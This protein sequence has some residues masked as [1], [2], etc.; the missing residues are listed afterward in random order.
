ML[1]SSVWANQPLSLGQAGQ[2]ILWPLIFLCWVEWVHGWLAQVKVSNT[3][4]KLEEESPTGGTR[5]TWC[6]LD[7]FSCAVAFS[8]LL[9]PCVFLACDNMPKHSWADVLRQVFTV[10]WRSLETFVLSFIMYVRY[11][12]TMSFHALGCGWLKTKMLPKPP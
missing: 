5:A 3:H 1:N 11:R 4:L 8:V 6:M 10:A 12:F 7:L 2:I 9:P